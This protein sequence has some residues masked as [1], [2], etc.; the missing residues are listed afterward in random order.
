[1]KFPKEKTAMLLEGPAGKIEAVL[2][3]P[4][5]SSR[6]IVGIVCHPHPLYEGNMNNKVVTTVARAFEILNVVA[7]R[8]NFRGVGKSEGEYGNFDGEIEDLKAVLNWVET[9]FPQHDVWLAG[10]SFGSYIAASVANQKKVAALISVAPAVNHRDFTKFTHI[11][12]P[13]W[14]IQGAQDEL[15]PVQEVKEWA[16]HPPSPLKLIVFDDAS[17]FFHGK[18]IELRECLIQVLETLK[19][20]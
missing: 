20:F 13:W 9:A 17:H 14:V 2:T 1:M 3:S 8:F 11:Q 16:E 19:D 4:A 6:K 12:C 10:F 7:V 5:D 18:L 15:V